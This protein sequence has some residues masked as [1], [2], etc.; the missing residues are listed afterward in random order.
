M[1][2]ILFRVSQNLMGIEAWYVR[3]DVDTEEE[4]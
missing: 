3:Y 1:N 4:D 2:W